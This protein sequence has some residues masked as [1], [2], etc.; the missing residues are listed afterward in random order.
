MRAAQI[1]LALRQGGGSSS[2]SKEAQGAQNAQDARCS[3]ANSL[4]HTQLARTLLH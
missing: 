3:Q 2:G 1:A 4:S